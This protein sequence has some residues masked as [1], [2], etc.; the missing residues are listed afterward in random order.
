MPILDCYIKRCT[1]RSEIEYLEHNK[2]DN[3]YFIVKI[4][5]NFIKH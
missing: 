2:A 1:K 4:N 3:L 5:I